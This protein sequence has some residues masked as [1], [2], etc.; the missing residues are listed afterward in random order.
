MDDVHTK[1]LLSLHHPLETAFLHF[2]FSET[3]PA[4]CDH[5]ILLHSK[6]LKK[7]H[8]NFEHR[9]TN[10]NLTPK[11][12]HDQ[13]FYMYKGGNPNVFKSKILAYL[14]ALFKRFDLN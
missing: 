10:K 3:C 7:C 13:V 8:K 11:N 6:S 12:D 9:S 2:T 14:G 4:K 5:T 1:Q